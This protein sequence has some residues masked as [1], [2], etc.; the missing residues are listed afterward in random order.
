M[1]I[2]CA[3]ILL[4]LSTTCFAQDED[5]EAAEESSASIPETIVVD[6][7]SFAFPPDTVGVGVK[8]LESGVLV[9][10]NKG[11]DALVSTPL[12]LRI[13]THEDFEWR[14]STSGV[15]FQ[16]SDVGWSD[17]STG[18]KWRFLESDKADVSLLTSLNVPVG[19]SAFRGDAVSGNV[20]LISNFPVADNT[21][22]LVNLG[23]N[24][25]GNSGR[26]DVL[27]GYFTLG[28]AQSLTE[29]LSVYVEVAGFTPQEVGGPSTMAGDVCFAYLIDDNTSFDFAG[30]KGF[31]S[32][33]LDWSATVGLS[34]RF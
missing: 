27:V 11:E 17:L 2:F 21:G 25:T 33:G 22:I 26:D 16:N 15:N 20:I 1:K 31:S 5:S 4:L 30:F 6:R 29:R 10:R 19:S 34:H 13:G 18:F 28:V 12:L 32:S 24:T 23:A 14:F 8:S 7:P 9:T 3:M